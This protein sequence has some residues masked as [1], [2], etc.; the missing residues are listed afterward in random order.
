VL[1]GVERHAEREVGEASVDAVHLVDR[2]LVVFELVV[3][4]T[5]LED[6][7]EEVVGEDIL[8][9]EAGGGDGFEAGEVGDVGGVAAIDG[10]EGAVGELVVVAVV[11]EGGGALGGIL[12][13]GLI[14]LFKESV[15]GS[16][17]RVDGGGLGVE[18]VREGDGEAGGEK[19][20]K[21]PWAHEGRVA[22]VI[23]RLRDFCA[24]VR[25]VQAATVPWWKKSCQRLSRKIQSEERW[26]TTSAVFAE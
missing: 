19:Q 12:E 11:S 16:E 4:E 25:R 9:G 1:D 21:E 15:L 14:E 20:R 6:A 17:A 8:L 18:G 23:S 13:V 22:D 5:L 3:V 26:E 24:A 7:S 2:H 10:G